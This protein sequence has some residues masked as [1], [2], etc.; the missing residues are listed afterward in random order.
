MQVNPDDLRHYYDSLSD[1]ALLEL[2]R[3]T[4]TVVA[5]QCY[6][7][8]LAQRKLSSRN[9]ESSVDSHAAVTQPDQ[10]DAGVEIDDEFDI[11]AQPTPD[12]LD[13][14]ACA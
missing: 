10:G 8:E 12:W 9:A 6:D 5:Q 7:D 11:D 3:A 14:A 1:D 2:D 4:L 13:D